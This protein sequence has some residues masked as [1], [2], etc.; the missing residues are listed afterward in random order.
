MCTEFVADIS[1]EATLNYLYPSPDEPAEP[2][3]PA[4][5]IRRCS[6][7]GAQWFMGTSTAAMSVTD[8]QQAESSG[9]DLFFAGA[10]LGVLGAL[11]LELVIA[12]L[13]LA[14]HLATSRVSPSQT[15][16]PA[17]TSEPG[18][19]RSSGNSRC[20]SRLRSGDAASMVGR[21]AGS[22]RVHLS[23]VLIPPSPARR[24]AD[25][26]AVAGEWRACSATASER[27][28]ARSSADSS[29]RIRARHF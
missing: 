10:F 25:A 2:D 27:R 15:P 8:L 18:P 23:S 26:R 21:H 9:R 5:K 4:T 29:P 24:R 6:E 1:A 7:P 14:E 13:D 28:W 3:N 20:S 22:G 19:E 12:I 17:P 11:A 16:T